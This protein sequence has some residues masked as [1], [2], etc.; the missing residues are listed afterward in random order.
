MLD[1]KRFLISTNGQLYS[2]P[3]PQAIARIIDINGP[4]TE[5]V[6]NY[7]SPQN[8]IWDSEYLRTEHNFKT[9]Y[10]EKKDAGITVLL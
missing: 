7:K 8:K 9:K 3:H 6:F 5:L 4:D 10:P 2:H 1:C